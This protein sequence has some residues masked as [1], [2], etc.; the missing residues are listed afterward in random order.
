MKTNDTAVQELLEYFDGKLTA[1]ELSAAEDLSNI[2]TTI[3]TARIK[4][5]MTQAEFAE[6]MNVSQSMVSKWENG[7]YNFT[8]EKIH[9]IAEKIGVNCEVRFSPVLEN[10]EHCF[11]TTGTSNVINLYDQSSVKT[12]SAVFSFHNMSTNC[13]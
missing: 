5:G 3:T 1:S 6:F 13:L 7:D 11:F 4:M 9:E 10:N 2:A 8:I 12:K